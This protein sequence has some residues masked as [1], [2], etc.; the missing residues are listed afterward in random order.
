MF[1]RLNR[2]ITEIIDPNSLS[3]KDSFLSMYPT[4]QISISSKMRF[5]SKA[6]CK[7]EAGS[8]AELSLASDSR[9]EWYGAAAL[10]LAILL[11]APFQSPSLQSSF[12][13]WIWKRILNLASAPSRRHKHKESR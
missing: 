9:S 1:Q 4:E 13:L 11:N 10:T 8:Q 7:P 12:A 3:D 2:S 5:S 6:V